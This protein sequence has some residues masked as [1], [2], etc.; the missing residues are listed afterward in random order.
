MRNKASTFD[1][2][3]NDIGKEKYLIL[4]EITS[5]KLNWWWS[6]TALL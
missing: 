1:A 4:L 3:M 6:D 2:N 5:S